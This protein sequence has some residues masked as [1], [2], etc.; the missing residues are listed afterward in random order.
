MSRPRKPVEILLVEDS[1]DDAELMVEALSACALP[2][3]V[4]VLEDGEEAMKYLRHEDPYA[5]APSPNMVIL[6]LH[7]PRKN[8]YEVLLEVKQ[9]RHLR[10][11]PVVILTSFDTTHTVCQVY[12]AHAN[13]FVRK[14]A[15]LEEFA[16]AVQKIEQFWLQVAAS[17]PP[18]RP[19]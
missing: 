12:E 3:R 6:D 15:D 11:I 13:C 2:T 17:N 8:G 19:S 16:L 1:P 7:L 10:Q 9:D 5:D 14:P 18:P 4:T